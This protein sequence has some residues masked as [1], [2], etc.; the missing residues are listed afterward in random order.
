MVSQPKLP[1]ATSQ[2]AAQ[3]SAELGAAQGSAIINNANEYTPW[4]SKTYAKSGY[5]TIYDAKGNPQKVPRYNSTVKLSPEQQKLLD[6]QNK[7]GINLG[8]IGVQQSSKI[9]NLLNTS[10]SKKGMT[11]WA[12]GTAPDQAF[13]GDPNVDRTAIEKAMMARQTENMQRDNAAQDAQLAARGMTPGSGQYS[14][15]QQGR[16]RQRTDAVNQAYLASGQE[17]RAQQQAYNQAVGQDNSA[18]MD[19][20]SFLNNLR[21]AQYN[22]ASTDRSR[23]LNEIA[24]LMSGSQVS[25]PQF[26]PFSR[27]SINAA[28]IGQYMGQNYQAQAN[29]AAN[30]N[31]GLF[32]LGSAGIT[33]A[34]GM[35]DRR[36][37]RDIIRITGTLAGCPLF[38]FRYI[39]SDVL[40]VGVMSDDVRA[41]HPDAVVV[42]NDGYDRVNY[43][44]LRA[45][46]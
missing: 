31:A 21:G 20:W 16:D 9:G 38:A 15:V 25:T 33:G 34:F 10:M 8:N 41:I 40:Q 37:K 27:Q 32:G 12:A 36:M 4:G 42:A 44:L 7:T 39:D 5:E 3:Q 2:A 24:A 29:A 13:R 30:T 11:P 6:L 45:R 1:S 19:Y 46:A 28:P 26:Q 35:S 23:P 14:T 18:N 22:E 43:D 17:S